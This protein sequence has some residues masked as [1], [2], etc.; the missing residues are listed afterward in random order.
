MPPKKKGTV[1]LCLDEVSRSDKNLPGDR[2]V[3]RCAGVLRGVSATDAAMSFRGRGLLDAPDSSFS[4]YHLCKGRVGRKPKVASRRNIPKGRALF[5]CYKQGGSVAEL[6]EYAETLPNSNASPASAYSG[7]DTRSPVRTPS[8][9]PRS[10]SQRRKQSRSAASQTLRNPRAGRRI[11]KRFSAQRP[12]S[13]RKLVP[14]SKLRRRTTRRS[15]S[16]TPS[17]EK[18]ELRHVNG[19]KAYEAPEKPHMNS[20]SVKARAK[21]FEQLATAGASGKP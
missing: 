16:A 4:E 5:R 14:L 1:G 9:S 20:T 3:L 7:S 19:P 6:E 2:V 15:K 13:T 12:A 8:A 10:Q 21:F 11:K 18:V 17:K